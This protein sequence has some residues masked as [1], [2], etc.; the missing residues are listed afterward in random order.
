MFIVY[1]PPSKL[2]TIKYF[3]NECNF[4]Q[5]LDANGIGFNP[6]LGDVFSFTEKEKAMYFFKNKIREQMNYLNLQIKHL[7]QNY[8]N[9]IIYVEG[10]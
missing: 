5:F 3:E 10:V 1:V 2:D 8:K 4:R 9:N 7:E 6:V